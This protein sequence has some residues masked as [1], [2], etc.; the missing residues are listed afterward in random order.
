MGSQAVTRI[1]GRAL[2]PVEAADGLLGWLAQHFGRDARFRAEVANR[3][4]G[5]CGVE[6]AQRCTWVPA[7]DQLAAAL[8]F[9]DSLFVVEDQN[10]FVDE[11]RE[12]KRWVRVLEGL[13]WDDDADDETLGRLD[14]WIRAG[15]DRLGW[16]VRQEDGPLGW[17][18]SPRVFAICTRLVRASVA[19]MA[20]GR[21]SPALREATLRA[22]EALRSH[23]ARVS[24]L[25]TEAWEDEAMDTRV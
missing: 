20:L 1:I 9:D 21:A 22:R 24:R 3:V 18:S 4:V 6:A 14:G 12:T 16:L 17:A 10:L 7:E 13:P 25:L 11:V 5:H 19:I 15:V 2:V 23:D 8:R